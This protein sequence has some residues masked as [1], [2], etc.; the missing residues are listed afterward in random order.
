MWRSPALWGGGGLRCVGNR[1]K[2]RSSGL[3][4]ISGKSFVSSFKR[5]LNKGFETETFR[6]L[7]G[8]FHGDTATD[9]K[10]PSAG[11]SQNTRFHAFPHWLHFFRTRWLRPFLYSLWLG[12]RTEGSIK[13]YKSYRHNATMLSTEQLLIVQNG[14]HQSSEERLRQRKP[15]ISHVSWTYSAKLFPFRILHINCFS[16]KNKK[17]L[18]WANKL[19]WQITNFFWIFAISISFFFFQKLSSGREEEMMRKGNNKTQQMWLSSI[20]FFFRL[21]SRL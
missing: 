19:F 16:A 21:Q 6:V 10:S 1:K 3:E 15:L 9:Q 7:A 20:Y 11:D 12:P 18:E 8:R 17:H 13:K 2:F 14:R 5:F 4:Q